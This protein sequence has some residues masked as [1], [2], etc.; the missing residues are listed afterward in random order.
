MKFVVEAPPFALKSPLVIVEE[1]LER[2]PLVK[3][4]KPLMPSVPRVNSR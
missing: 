2:K 1:A 3:V 4:V